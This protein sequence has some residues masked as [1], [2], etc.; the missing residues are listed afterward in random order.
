VPRLTGFVLSMLLM[1]P[2]GAL[3]FS[4][5]PTEVN[6]FCQDSDP[7]S[8]CTLCHGNPE[9]T[10]AYLASDYCYFCPTDSAC[11]TA[12]TCTDADGDGYAAEGGDC[13]QVDCNDND[14]TINPGAVEDCTDGVDNNCD[15]LVDAA[16]P[17]AVN[18]PVGCT[19]MDGDGFSPD[20]GDCG[21]I[22]CDDGDPDINPAATEA[23]T[24]GI[25]N[26]CN[27]LVDNADPNAVG[28]PLACTDADGDGYALEGGDCGAVDCNDADP[29][30][31]PGAPEVCTDGIDNN[32]NGLMD[33]NDGACAVD[34]DGEEDAEEETR[35]KKENRGKGHD[36]DDG[37]DEEGEDE[38]GEDEE[39]EDEEDDD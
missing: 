22:D 8:G 10:A 36:R 39:E 35:E 32:C 23:C 2:L 4:S 16:D 17:N 15:G 24:D 31:N 9:P 6:S 29:T 25:D 34:D 7:V 12:P 33:G 18:C 14:A 28:C 19:D 21:Q 37:P 1:A 30:V 3:A 20:G 26:N 27:D 11:V 38:E 5:A 13:G